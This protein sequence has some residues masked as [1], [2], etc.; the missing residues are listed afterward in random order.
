MDLHLGDFDAWEVDDVRVAVIVGEAPWAIFGCSLS[1]HTED[2]GGCGNAAASGSYRG[3][4]VPSSIDGVLG[5]EKEVHV[6]DSVVRRA[7][8]LGNW[9]VKK[10]R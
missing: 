5:L 1:A 7:G 8:E 3:S 4:S 6:G 9:C 2:R 10:A